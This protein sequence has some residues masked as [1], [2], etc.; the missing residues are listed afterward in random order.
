MKQQLILNSN[1]SNPNITQL[2]QSDLKECYLEFLEPP[3][4]ALDLAI[5]YIKIIACI[6]HLIF[7]LSI[8]LIKEFH[9]RHSV[10][11]V[12]LSLI[13]FIY[14]ING[15][16]TYNHDF[17]CNL[18]SS[19]FCQYQGIYFQVSVFLYSYAV[20]AMALYR[21]ACV[22]HKNLNQVFKIWKIVLSL[23]IIWLIP[24]FFVIIPKYLKKTPIFYH[25]SLDSC[26]INYTKQTGSFVFFIL[27]GFSFPS[28]LIAILYCVIVFKIN[29][30]KNKIKNLK[31]SLNVVF[32]KR[33]TTSIQNENTKEV[34]KVQEKHVHFHLEK[35][36]NFPSMTKISNE[37][38][39]NLNSKTYSIHFKLIL[40]FMIIFVSYIVYSVSNIILMYQT[41]L[42][43]GEHWRRTWIKIFKTFIWIYHL[44]NPI[45]YLV[46]HCI[47]IEKIKKKISIKYF[48]SNK[49]NFCNKK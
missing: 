7:F 24:V 15:L 22:T 9:S 39:R 5:K 4:C 23:V 32:I 46:F 49:L 48:Y 17:V 13:G 27:F 6:L 25:H 31:Q 16:I 19:L 1:I 36:S 2:F 3:E 45:V 12:N 34:V 42:G 44:I 29:N 21:L 11:Q 10:Y 35:I 14:V 43:K 33:S 37:Q 20:L 18:N 40:Q 38:E 8:F 28:I 41:M 30:T 26:Q 47:V